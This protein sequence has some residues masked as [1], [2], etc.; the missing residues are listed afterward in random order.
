M[1]LKRALRVAPLSR[2]H[3]FPVWK[4]GRQRRPRGGSYELVSLAMK[5]RCSSVSFGSPPVSRYAPPNGFPVFT[6]HLE[7]DL[8]H[9]VTFVEY[10]PAMSADNLISGFN[11]MP[12]A[13]RIPR[14]HARDDFPQAHHLEAVI[15]QVQLRLGTAAA[16][17]SRGIAD[18]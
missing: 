5:A 11:Q 8:I 13:L 4:S 1:R 17:P 3:G 10:V 7:Q 9:Q 16:L 6:E 15:E 12:Q 18:N 2:T 14:L